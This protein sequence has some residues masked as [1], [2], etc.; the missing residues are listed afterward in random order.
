MANQT[1]PRWILGL[2]EGISET[3]RASLKALE[4]TL[5]RL[6]GRVEYPSAQA[7]DRVNFNTATNISTT[8]PTAITNATFT[9]TPEVDGLA[10]ITGDFSA[11]CATFTAVTHYF[12]GLLYINGS[13]ISST[14]RLIGSVMAVSDRITGSRTWTV[15]VLAKKAYTFAL[16]ALTDNVGTTYNTA[17]SPSGGLT[18]VFYPGPYEYPS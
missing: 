15:P 7:Y 3:L 8:T 5:S 13:E 6:H 10:V 18:V 17:A 9:F 2:P 1:T 16:Y 14:V 11:I 12:R 4:R